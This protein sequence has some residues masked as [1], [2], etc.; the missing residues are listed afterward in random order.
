MALTWRG[1][2]LSKGVVHESPTTRLLRIRTLV[3]IYD[4]LDPSI[5]VKAHSFETKYALDLFDLMTMVEIRDAI[6]EDGIGGV[7]SLRSIAEG[8]L[9]DWIDSATIRSIVLPFNFNPP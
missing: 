7:P 3:E 9:Q 2:V 1:S 8:I 4:D 6:V 5:V